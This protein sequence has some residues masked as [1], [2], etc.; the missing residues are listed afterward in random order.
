MVFALV[1]ILG[2]GLMSDLNGDLA[3]C[4]QLASAA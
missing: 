2:A 4:L 1:N 3:S